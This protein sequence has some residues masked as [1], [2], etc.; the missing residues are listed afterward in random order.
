LLVGLGLLVDT[1]FFVA[2]LSSLFFIIDPFANVPLFLSFT[3]GFP[4]KERRV[5]V[6]NAHVIALVVFVFFCVFGQYVFDFLRVDFS[7][8]K[9]AG[10]I[11]LF[12]ISIEMLFGEKTHT[13]TTHDEQAAAE[14]R[15]NVTVSPLAI[16]LIAGPGLI[17]TGIVLFSRVNGA[18][19]LLSFGLATL[20]AFGMSFVLLS[21]SERLSKFLGL[22]GL[23][24]ITRIMGLLLMAVAI[25]FV[26]TGIMES[27]LLAAL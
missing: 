2:T 27:G 20:V 17:T 9:I 24:V 12:L 3:R 11:L 18:D 22:V 16:P 1:V 21:E 25:Q 7:S 14:E 8:F 26:V 15:E 4:E 5:I 19:R 13:E 6:R 23:K 10:G